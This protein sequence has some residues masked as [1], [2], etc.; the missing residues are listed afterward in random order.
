LLQTAAAVA[1][2]LVPPCCK[3]V[4]EA[5]GGGRCCKRQRP[6]LQTGE[7]PCCKEA[8]EAVGGGRRWWLLQT[9]AAVATIRAPPCYT[10]AG[11]DVGGATTCRR[12]RYMSRTGGAACERAALLSKLGSGSGDPRGHIFLPDGCVLFS[13]SSV[14]DVDLIWRLLTPASNGWRPGGS[15]I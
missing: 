8:G 2:N 4:G 6:L 15:G 11:E 14:R 9:A 5:V 12:R 10:E 13:F 7:P 3:E 1:T